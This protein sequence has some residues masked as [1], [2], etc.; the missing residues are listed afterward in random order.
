MYPI[1]STS[2]NLL[3]QINRSQQSYQANL[4][5]VSTGRRINSA[6]DGAAL[7][8]MI[9]RLDTE[10]RAAT[11]ATQNIGDALS[12]GA[13]ADAGAQGVTDNIQRIRELSVQAANDTLTD[14][15]RQTIQQEI[16]QLRSGINDIASSTNFNQQNLLDGSFTNQNFQVGSNA[17]DSVNLSVGSLTTGALG[18]DSIDVTTSANA[19]A[20]ITSSSDALET[21]LSVRGQIGSFQNSMATRASNLVSSNIQNSAT[22]SRMRDTDFASAS[23]QLQMSLLQSSTSMAALA[24][25]NVSENSILNLFR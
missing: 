12:L 7:S 14:S 18:L 17:S 25:Y 20:A 4:L 15:D 3:Q 21:T 8:A 5:R 13:V 24:H 9:S 23:T 10:I 1:G 2:G 22:L 6:S 16:N 11:Q 19:R